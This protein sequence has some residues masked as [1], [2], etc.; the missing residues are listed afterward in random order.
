M[1]RIFFLQV[2]NKIELNREVGQRA[3]KTEA[4]PSSHSHNHEL[5]ALVCVYEE[6]VEKLTEGKLSLTEAS[7]ECGK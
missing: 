7:V 6:N 3:W 5:D 1:M 4:T 2:V